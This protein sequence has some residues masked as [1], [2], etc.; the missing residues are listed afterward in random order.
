[1]TDWGLLGEV[2]ANKSSDRDRANVKDLVT[3]ARSLLKLIRETFPRYTMHDEQ[4]A[5]N[6]IAL[7]GRLAA[8]RIEQMS[9]LEAALLILA[10]YFHDAGMAYRA[11]EIASIPDE[12]EFQRFLDRHDDAVVATQQNGGVPPGAVVEQY[13]RERHAER[14]RVHLDRC[15]RTMLRWDGK[16]IID[17][18]ELVCRSHNEGAAALHEPRF[19]TD[20]LYQ[21]DLRFCAIMLRLADILDLDDTR[22]PKVIYEH[23]GLA[24]HTTPEVAASDREWNKHLIARGFEF[25]RTPA[26]NYSLQFTAESEDPGNE[27][28]LRA[29]LRVIEEELQR[30]RSVADICDE[31]WR[32]LPLPAQIDESGISSRGYRYGEF[33]FEL[34]RSAVLNLFTGEQLYDD[35]YAFIRELLQNALD[36]IRAREHLYEHRSDGVHVRGWKDDGGYLWLRVDDDGIG[37]DEA[38]LR[39]FFLRIGRSYYHST[40]FQATL[41]RS[42]RADQPFG[43]IGRF[44]IGVLSCFVVGDQVELSSRPVS[45]GKAV[46][47]SIK[48]QDDYFVLQD[49]DMAGRP[50]PGPATAEP[51]FPRAPGTRIAVRVDPNHVELD[52]DGLLAKVPTYLFAPPVPVLVNDRAV[53][54]ATRQLVAEPL[55]AQPLITD[56]HLERHGKVRIAAVPLNLTRDGECPDVSGQLLLYIALPPDDAG[57]GEERSF[58]SLDRPDEFEL[59]AGSADHLVLTFYKGRR[60][61]AHSQIQLSALPGGAQASAFLAHGSQWGFNGIALPAM[62]DE[63]GLESEGVAAMVLGC[64]SLSGD[65]RP[66]LTVSRS[67]VRYLP[68]PVH[69]ALQL[70]TR[71]ALRKAVTGRT[72]IT[73]R[74]T[75]RQLRLTNLAPVEPFVM[76]TFR[77]DRLLCGGSWCAEKMQGLGG[78]SIEDLHER[79]RNGIK[80]QVFHFP[81]DPRQL[82]DRVSFAFDDAIMAAL[83]HLF[84]DTECVIIGSHV[85]LVVKTDATPHRPEGA[86]LFAP[87]FSAP[88]PDNVSLARAGGIMNADHPL[89]KW[90]LDNAHALAEHLPAL[91]QRVLRP[92]NFVDAAE[93]DLAL[94]RVSDSGRV[95]APPLAAY[96][97]QDENG[98]W[99][100]R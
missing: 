48:R 39:K 30:C 25:P 26:A 42:G 99:W 100:S 71:R 56:L 19:R 55:I 61:R 69:S 78:V 67:T 73:D 57:Q 65:L 46:R 92:A 14:V 74:Y 16:P 45:G 91:F 89:T 41:A 17:Q 6:V 33:R 94:K 28:R 29:F 20:F 95:P 32:G 9:G 75:F 54:R 87:M 31:R 88:F 58:Y 10:A 68:F 82:A 85:N 8:P 50:M 22:S 43:V 51:A 7:M 59:P 18:L 1:M 53:D 36:A 63:R 49:Q 21:A 83:L 86:D 2:L 70:A 93:W 12:E 38:T 72:E 76:S 80:S 40:E 47:L 62:T 35:P 15:D 34:D 77:A 4:H 81:R 23:L 98:W 5:E 96:V 24:E 52:L 3:H 84:V 44:G 97:R 11:D 64:L 37:M 66:D 13:C 79:A 60:R 27:H 90:L